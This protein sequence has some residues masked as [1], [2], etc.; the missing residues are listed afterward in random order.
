VADIFF[1]GIPGLLA[2]IFRCYL[3]ES[4]DG[5]QES[6]FVT[7]GYVGL[8]QA[9]KALRKPWQEVLREHKLSYFKSSE[10]RNLQGE[11]WKLKKRFGLEEGHRR[12][13]AIR[14]ELVQVIE[15]GE[16]FGFVMG[17]DLKQFWQVDALPE[18][19]S[20]EHWDSNYSTLGYRGIFYSV[21]AQIYDHPTYPDVAFVCDADEGQTKYRDE[22]FYQLKKRWPEPGSHLR[23]ISHLDDKCIVGLQMA[24]AMA[25]RGRREVIKKIACPSYK[26]NLGLRTVRIDCFHRRG[27]LE[28]LRGN[29]KG[30]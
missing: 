22:A 24:D 29:L 26:A 25:D 12:A 28:I 16:I 15:Q 5:K 18:A 23:G 8:P 4:A 14:D 30:T 6:E 17:I 21:A 27:M 20:S 10:C 2:M 3:D 13:D 9:W 7:A 1:D 11:F 19:K